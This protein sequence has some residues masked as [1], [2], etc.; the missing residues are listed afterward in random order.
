VAMKKLPAQE[1]R[2]PVGR[3]IS[4][5][6]EVTRRIRAVVRSEA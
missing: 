4:A 5:R 3:P 1:A 2:A 6:V